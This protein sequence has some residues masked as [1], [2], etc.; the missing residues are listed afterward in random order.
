MFVN[1]SAKKKLHI[2]DLLET[3]L[4]QADVLELR[5]NPD[6]LASGFVI[7]A[8][9]D[10]RPRPCG[11]RARAARHRCIRATPSSPARPMAVSVRWS[12]RAVSMSRALRLPTRS[13]SWA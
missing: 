5:A 3:I 10:K 4:L 1:V 8:N 12:T 7:E 11:H 2:D 6:A 13:R 9:L